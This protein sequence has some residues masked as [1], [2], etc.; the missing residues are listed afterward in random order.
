ME[1]LLLDHLKDADRLL[2]AAGW[3]TRSER[4]GAEYKPTD[5]EVRD[6]VKYSKEMKLSSVLDIPFF[7]FSIKDVSRAFTHQWVRYR[8]AA[9]MQQ[10]LRY[11]NISTDSSSWFVVPPTVS[12][13]GHGAVVGYMRNQ[14]SAAESYRKLI[15][16]G[17]PIEDARFALPIGTK[18][19]ITTAMNG[20]ELLHVFSQRCC[21]DAQW[22]IRAVSYALL[23]A[24]MMIAPLLFEGAGP[25]CIG[26]GVCRGS[27]RGKCKG[28]SLEIIGKIRKAI[29]GRKEEYDGMGPG[30]LE[31]DLTDVLGYSAPAGL[32]AGVRR[33][34]GQE[35]G[36]DVPVKLKI[37]K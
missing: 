16:S 26:D 21:T 27:G 15:D 31:L 35:A 33:E 36:L 7:V 6:M 5:K 20:E 32:K 22:E 2:A 8:V 11:V 1:V 4:C 19:H 28:E 13:K 25:H 10:S 30:W 3:A 17:V 12:E 37:R 18:T 23:A 24:G 29:A 14:R 9:H 34:F